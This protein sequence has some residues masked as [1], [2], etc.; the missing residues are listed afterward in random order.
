MWSNELKALS[1]K[2]LDHA[3]AHCDGDNR[4][5]AQKGIEEG[6]NIFGEEGRGSGNELDPPD[7]VLMHWVDQQED[8]DYPDN[9]AMT[10][11][12]WVGS[13]YVGCASGSRAYPD[14]RYCERHVW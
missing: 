5:H 8:L 6:Q 1:I 3:L 11:V 14:N 13:N 7:E 2:V 9:S 10:Q 12:L 4:L